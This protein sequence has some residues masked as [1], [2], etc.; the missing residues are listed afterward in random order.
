MYFQIVRLVKLD[1]RRIRYRSHLWVTR[2]APKFSEG[3]AAP[4]TE[5]LDHANTSELHGSLVEPKQDCSKG[6]PYSCRA[7]V[8]QPD[9]ELE[10]HFQSGCWKLN[11][12]Q[13]LQNSVNFYIARVGSEQKLWSTH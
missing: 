3:A 6:Q 4:Y 11:Y 10:E 13:G 9:A 1:W 12:T 5:D 8:M 7:S 2:V